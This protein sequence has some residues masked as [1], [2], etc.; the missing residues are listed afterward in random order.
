MNI[1]CKSC[2]VNCQITNYDD[3]LG[4]HPLFCPFCGEDLGYDIDKIQENEMEK[5]LDVLF[6]PSNGIEL[7]S[8]IF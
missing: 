1:E 8:D 3:W 6:E 4:I 2:V 5:Y 7:D